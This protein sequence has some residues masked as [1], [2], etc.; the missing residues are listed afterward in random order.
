MALNLDLIKLNV[1]KKNY[2]VIFEI[3]DIVG[4]CVQVL[5]FVR[6]RMDQITFSGTVPSE[7]Y[8]MKMMSFSKSR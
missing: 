6:R 2:D 3:N 8:T 7:L 4:V 5:F 1:H